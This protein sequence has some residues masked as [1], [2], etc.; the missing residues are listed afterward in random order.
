VIG[1]AWAAL[2]DALAVGP[3][4]RILEVGCG[5]GGFCALAAAR[6]AEAAGIDSDPHVVDRARQRVPTADVRTGFMEALPWAQGSFDAVVGFNAFQYASDIDLALRE[7]ARVLRT[8]GRL[9]VG[10]WGQDSELF[11]LAVA[12]GAG[13]PGA[14]RV[15]DPVEEALSR[16][17]LQVSERGDVPVELEVPDAGALAGAVGVIDAGAL[18][19][20]AEAYRRADGSYRFAA[21]VT[22]LVAAE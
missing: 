8:G 3:G 14:L 11:S 18:A 5:D 19:E 10:K 15:R 16:A 12:I 17:G 2:A 9:G 21:A 6:G 13:R 7:A 4:M 20:H 22:Y 1:A